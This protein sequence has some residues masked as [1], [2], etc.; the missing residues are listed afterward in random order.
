MQPFLPNITPSINRSE[1]VGADIENQTPLS[2]LAGT[3]LVQVK[4][5]EAGNV[6]TAA[7]HNIVKDHSLRALAR[8]SLL[9]NG[10]LPPRVSL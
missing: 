8:A 6:S 5:R 3:V 9:A 4:A 2:V 10:W 7:V 1:P